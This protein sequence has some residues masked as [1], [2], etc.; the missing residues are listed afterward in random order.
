MK[1]LFILCLFVFFFSAC[2]TGSS[3]EAG[4]PADYQRSTGEALDDGVILTKVKTLLLRDP[5]V[6]GL[7]I[8]VNVFNQVVTLKGFVKSRE[9]A[10]RAMELAKGVV[11]VKEVQSKLVLDG[12][13]LEIY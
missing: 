9:E 10:F 12:E 7:G 13:I 3:T 2:S 6:S 5:K 4:Y 11:N 8:E 1:K